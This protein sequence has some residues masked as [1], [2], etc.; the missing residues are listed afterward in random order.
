MTEI[1]DDDEKRPDPEPLADGVVEGEVAD[2]DLPSRCPS[3]HLG[4]AEHGGGV[5][6]RVFLDQRDL[7]IAV[8]ARAPVALEPE[9]GDVAGFGERH[10]RP[11]VLVD[12]MDGDDRTGHAAHQRRDSPTAST[13]ARSLPRPAA[14]AAAWKRVGG[15][16]GRSSVRS[17]VPQCMATACRAFR[18]TA[19]RT[20]SSGFMCTNC[21]ISGGSYAP[22]GSAARSIGPK[23]SPISRKP[24][25]YPVSPA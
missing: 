8:R 24:A 19:A 17:K 2:D 22:I 20:A 16:S 5:R 11:V 21:M 25:K 1:L 3:G 14:S 15:S 7:P 6:E 18:S 12:A 9:V 4:E 23:R 13:H 10:G